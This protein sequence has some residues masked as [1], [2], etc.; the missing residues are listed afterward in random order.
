VPNGTLPDGR[1]RYN[2]L[3]GQ[4]G[5]NTDI[6]LTNAGFGDSWN[7]V[8]RFDKR[9]DSG[10][11]LNGAYTFGDV[12]DQS[13]GTS[14]VAF[15]N[16]TNT[17][18]GIDSNF[19][20]QGISNYQRDHQFRL[21]AGFDGEIFGENNTRIELF[22]NLR[23]GQRYSYTFA[24]QAAGSLRSSVLGVTGRNSAG[25][26][27]VP[28]VSSITA[29]P[30]VSYAPGFD[31][32]G[33]QQFILNSE[34][35]DFQGQIAPKNIAKT[36][37]VH[38]LDLAFRQEVPFVLGGKIEFSAEMEN[39]LNFIDKDWGTI[40]QVGFPYTAPVVNVA[41]LTSAA[42]TPGSAVATVSQPCAQ[43]R[44]ENRTGT[45][46]RAPVEAT[47]INGSLWGVR[48]GVRVKF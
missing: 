42:G 6:L 5:V 9:W 45:T 15:S 44:F 4:T 48:F 3:A 17:A 47:Q 39:V 40:R 22:Y 26:L 33:F 27:Y 16:Y 41:C 13:P 18:V 23:S 1:Q 32:S 31:F 8:G 12:A 21:G 10:L 2:I 36:P 25:L 43:Y 7:I 38:K 35:N 29:D 11:F 24:D 19:A 46:F 34:L 37:W 30:R 14:S 28:N 20:A